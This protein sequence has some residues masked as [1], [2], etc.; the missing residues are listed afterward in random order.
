MHGSTEHKHEYNPIKS[1]NEKNEN[2]R[3]R[4]IAEWKR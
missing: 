1:K 2:E 4:A 3:R